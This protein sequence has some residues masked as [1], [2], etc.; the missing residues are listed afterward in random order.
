M[1]LRIRLARTDSRTAK[2][3]FTTSNEGLLDTLR[4]NDQIVFEYCDEDGDVNESRDVNPNGA[5]ANIAGLCNPE[6]T[7]LAMM[8][9]PERTTFLRQ[10]PGELG[11]MWAEAKADIWGDAQRAEPRAPA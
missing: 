5:M 3:G 2:D 10:V 9:H 1:G 11:G 4:E 6:G 8:P 7:V